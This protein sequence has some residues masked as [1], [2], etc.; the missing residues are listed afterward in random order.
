MRSSLLKLMLGFG[1]VI[2]AFA[3][4]VACEYQIH[5]ATNGQASPSQTA[6][7]QPATQDQSN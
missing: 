5:A 6:Q 1:L 7:A 3:P 2:A 4:A